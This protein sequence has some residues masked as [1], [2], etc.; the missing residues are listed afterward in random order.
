MSKKIGSISIL[1]AISMMLLTACNQ[2]SPQPTGEVN[3]EATVNAMVQDSLQTQADAQAT[4]E[5]AV[6]ATQMAIESQATPVMVDEDYYKLTEEDLEA[7]I[8]EAVNTALNASA[9][10]SSTTSD[11]TY[12]NMVSDQEVVYVSYAVAYADEAIAYAEYLLD[13]YYDVYGAYADDAIGALYEVESELESIS[14]SLDAMEELLYQGADA[15]NAA[16]TELNDAAM[17]MED[18][19]TS[20]QENTQNWLSSYQATLDARQFELQNLQPNMEA[21]DRSQMV[22]MIN[23]YVDEIRAGVNDGRLDRDEI[24][25]ITQSGV[26]AQSAINKFGGGQMQGWSDSI[27]N[28]NRLASQGNSLELS[29]GAKNLSAGL[30]ELNKRR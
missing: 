24:Q 27:T 9:E 4:I 1:I 5:A 23:G 6:Q 7:L 19:L 16:M 22:D 30:P 20:A 12:D 2:T 3:L 14:N 26:N 13:V 28:M 25:R 8:D 15:V 18:K 17:Q 11:A 29:S 21:M 10:V